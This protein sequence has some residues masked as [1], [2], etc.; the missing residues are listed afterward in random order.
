MNENLGLGF[1]VVE[2]MQQIVLSI[3]DFHGHGIR[4]RHLRR[5]TVRTLETWS[6]RPTSLALGLEVAGGSRSVER[7]TTPD[8]FDHLHGE[9]GCLQFWDDVFTRLYLVGSRSMSARGHD[10]YDVV[11]CGNLRLQLPND[12]CPGLV[13]TI[14][15]CWHQDPDHRLSLAETVVEI[16][17]L[18]DSFRSIDPNI[19]MVFGLNEVYI[20][21]LSTL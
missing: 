16:K 7:G 1:N 17:R 2:Y 13:D 5:S 11:L 18:V 14:I 20:L 4:H 9:V 15:R 10:I 19:S 3:R 6:A 8:D 12:V 21:T